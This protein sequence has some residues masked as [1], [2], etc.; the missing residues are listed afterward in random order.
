L[1]DFALRLVS[2]QQVHE[3]E[4]ASESIAARTSTGVSGLDE[5]LRGGLVSNR[6]YMV[7]G[8]PGSGKTILGLQFLDW[9]VRRGDAALLITFGES[10]GELRRNGGE[11]GFAM[12]GIRILD[13]SP[14]SSRFA[15]DEE[16]DIFPPSEVERLPLTR[17]IREEVGAQR[18]VRVFV[19]GMTQLR[20][21]TS[22]SFHFRNEALAFLRF[23]CELGSTVL[24]SSESNEA[25]DEDLQFIADAII[26]LD[27]AAGHRTLSVLKFRGS[28]FRA[29]AH[30]LRLSST[31]MQVF[32]RLVP[33][34]FD[35]NFEPEQ[36]PF[37]LPEMDALVAGGLE[38][39]TIT[40][41]TG[42]SGVGKSSLG[43]QFV[44]AAALRGERAVVY[45]F[46]EQRELLIRRG[47]ALRIPVRQALASGRLQILQVEP[48]RYTADEFA[49]MVRHNVENQRA[50]IVMLDSVSGYRLSLRDQD[51]VI[52]LH[53][54]AK[55]LQ[56]MGVAVVLIN[57]V[58]A[59]TGDFRVTD[60]GVSYVADN[61]IFLRYIEINGEIAKALGVL[62]KRLSDF[63]KTLREVVLTPDGIRVGAK[64]TGLRG[65]LRGEPEWKD[66]G[67]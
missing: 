22:N 37:G 18:P 55:Y 66:P 67:A 63:E 38:R 41:L 26:Q 5:I 8:G 25:P 65:I 32:P 10:E 47:E 13:L 19:D 44:T 56:N 49:L 54:L 12:D 46:E 59:I 51:L 17:R 4:Q 33:D 48:L 1:A 16:Y 31:G 29:G 27:F 39:G 24:F 20:Y 28:D 57:E 3:R 43:M 52:H 6:S 9:A 45:L 7:R 21:L 40:I 62:K 36:I 14:D 53:A 15:L 64:L 35:M 42:P 30:T 11:L 23:L 34:D 2:Y 61:I 58:E 60:V 50:T